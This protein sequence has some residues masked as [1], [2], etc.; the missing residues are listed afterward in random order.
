MIAL[1]RPYRVAALIRSRKRCITP[2][3]RVHSGQRLRILIFTRTCLWP[4]PVLV[5]LLGLASGRG[6]VSS[7]QVDFSRDVLTIL[8]DNCYE[9]H[10]PDEKARKAKLRFDTKEGAF[11]V[12][13]GKTVIVPGKSGESEL[14]RRIITRDSDDLMPPPD[15]HHKLTARQIGLIRQWI[16]E[17]AKWGLRWT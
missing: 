12:K 8:S 17:G 7:S 13:D 14:F 16:D 6:A 3:V 1:R 2:T 11:R 15:S 5:M 10:G 9:C 4:C